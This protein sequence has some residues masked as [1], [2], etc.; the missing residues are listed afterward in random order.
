MNLG[1]RA[2]LAGLMAISLGADA[3]TPVWRWTDEAGHVN[4]AAQPPPG[5][6]AVRVDKGQ[7]DPSADSPAEAAKDAGDSGDAIKRRL[8]EMQ[9]ERLAREKQR[10]Q[11]QKIRQSVQQMAAE[12]QH[13]RSTLEALTARGQASVQEGDQYRVLPEE[14]R[15]SR[16][17]QTQ[18]Y[19]DTN[20]KADSARHQP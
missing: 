17:H 7:V 6:Q 5:I 16:I 11:E 2:A 15:Q 10:M 3:G 8:D 13:A 20:C 19:L 1:L 14:E 4:Y 9:K 12:C 18:D